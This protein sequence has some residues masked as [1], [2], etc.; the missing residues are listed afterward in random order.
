MSISDRDTKI[1]RTL[2]ERYRAVCDSDL[3]RERMR[4]W[5][6]HDA[7]EP[8]RPMV[9]TETDGGIRL[10]LPDWQP[11]CEGDLARHAEYQMVEAITH[12]DTIRDDRVALPYIQLRWQVQTSGYGV[13]V[14]QERGTDSHGGQTGYHWEAPIKDL[15]TDF[16]KLSPRTFSVNREKTLADKAEFERVFDGLLDVR[17]RGNFWWTMGLTQTAIYLIGLEELMLYMYDEPEMLHRFMAFL[18]DDHLAFVEWCEKENLLTLNNESDYIGSG[19]FGFSRAL[20]QPDWQEGDPVRAKDLWVLVESQETVGVGP[21]QFEEFIFPYQL[22]LAERF[23][24]SY[25]GCCEPVHNRWHILKRIP[26]LKRLSISPWCD[27]EFM[28]REM[29]RDYAFCRKPNPTLVSTDDFNEESI[30]K[31][32]NE[33]LTITGRHGCPTELV[34]KDVHTLNNQPQRLGRWVEIA[35][36]CIEEHRSAGV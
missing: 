29:G 22:S 33:T 24:R 9:L 20:P 5:Y 30:R 26:N 11:A 18:R 1:L 31:D 25:Y 12:A 10:V 15:E 17:I 36:A 7:G 34:M 2:A 21:E 13:E 14:K 16:E 3:N 6:A 32:I 28:A 23:G 35:R 8:E 4:L 27:Q 19:S